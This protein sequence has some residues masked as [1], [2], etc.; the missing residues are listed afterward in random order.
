MCKACETTFSVG[1]SIRRQKRSHANDDILWMIT[2]GLPISKLCDFTQLGPRDVYAKIDFIHRR[3]ASFTA[4]REG[5]FAAVNWHAVGRRFASDSQTLFLNW[6]SRKTRAQIPV[7]HLCTAHANSGYIMAVHLGLD[8]EAHMPDIEAAMDLSRFFSGQ[9]LML[10][11]P[12][13][14]GHG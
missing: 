9:M 4:R 13:F 1:K 14:E 10:G 11:G 12:L 5:M 8:P 6:P 3:V 7:H 2:N